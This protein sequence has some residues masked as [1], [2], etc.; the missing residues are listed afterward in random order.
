MSDKE[1]VLISIIAL[2]AL[3]LEYRI[4]TVDSRLDKMELKSHEHE[5]LPVTR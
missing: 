2:I 3:F 1:K 4:E 5:K